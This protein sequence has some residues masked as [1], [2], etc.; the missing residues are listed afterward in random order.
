MIASLTGKI[1]LKTEKSVI[2]EVN[3]TGYEIFA[4]LVFLEKIKTGSTTTVYT[5]LHVREDAMEL[6]GFS[7]PA[8]LAFF[9]LLIGV[10]GIGPK[11]AIAILSLASVSD[12]KKAISH[13]DASL[14][15]KVS[16]IGKK[17]AAR[18]IVELK[19]KVDR[20]DGTI[21]AVEA[22]NLGDNQAIDGL[23]HLGYSAREA[24]DALQ[25]VGADIT[26]VK[27]RVRAAL[28]LLGKK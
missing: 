19:T 8:E 22:E 5:H 24:R 26:Q 2:I 27:D 6:Y 10:S 15:T 23:V 25:Q 13:G 11:S 14:L 16:G 12:L 3:G 9:K 18:L 7:T 4:P 28:K 20:L 21:G 1:Q 17:T